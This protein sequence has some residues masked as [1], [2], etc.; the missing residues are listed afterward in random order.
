MLKK[1]LMILLVFLFLFSCSKTTNSETA[2]S[3]TTTSPNEDIRLN[4]DTPQYDIAD[5]H[6][7]YGA[8]DSNAKTCASEKINKQ[9]IDLL[10]SQS[11]VDYANRHDEK[12]KLNLISCKSFTIIFISNSIKTQVSFDVDQNYISTYRKNGDVTQELVAEIND[13]TIKEFDELLSNYIYGQTHYDGSL[14]IPAYDNIDIYYLSRLF[15]SNIETCSDLEIKSKTVDLLFSQKYVNYTYNED[16]KLKKININS[17]ML[18]FAFE[19]NEDIKKTYSFYIDQEHIYTSITDEGKATQ[20]YV[21]E[22]S[23]S[24]LAELNELLSYYSR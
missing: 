17:K 15:S 24:F 20:E 14:F 21:A 3:N 11:Y 2:S 7:F 6:Y 13:S 22:V 8:V 23:E 19:I 1:L 10:Y 18:N 12:P 4:L 5:V 9:I 16:E